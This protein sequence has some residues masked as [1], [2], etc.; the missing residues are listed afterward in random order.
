VPSPN[1]AIQI[2]SRENQQRSNSRASPEPGRSVSICQ[3]LSR[4]IACQYFRAT[5]ERGQSSDH[6]PH[7][8]IIGDITLW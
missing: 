5:E 1:F 7:L 4:T 3:E 8:F 2:S 6:V